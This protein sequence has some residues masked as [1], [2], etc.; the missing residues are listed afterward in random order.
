MVGYVMQNWQE[1]VIAIFLDHPVY[2]DLC[3]YRT[4]VY[5]SVVANNH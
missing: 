4:H 3:V 2:V 1:N 5:K